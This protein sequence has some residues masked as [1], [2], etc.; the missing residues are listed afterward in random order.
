MSKKKVSFDFDDCLDDLQVQQYCRELKERGIDVWICT[1]RTPSVLNGESIGD[2][3]NYGWNTDV[4]RMC[5]ELD[6]PDDHVI[7][8]DCGMKSDHLRGK[9]FIWHLDDMK[10]NI[11]DVTKNSDCIGV[12]YQPWKPDEWKNKCELLLKQNK[13][14]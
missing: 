6:I 3:I 13:D 12:L 8:T 2:S 14:E 10:P 11:I 5:A 1:A 7:M 4:F 9:G